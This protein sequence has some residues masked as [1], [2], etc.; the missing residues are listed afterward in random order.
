M[1]GRIASM[2]YNYDDDNGMI[3]GEKII[4]HFYFM[5]WA[6]HYYGFYGTNE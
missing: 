1:T 4:V 5:S 2:I 3:A 6:L